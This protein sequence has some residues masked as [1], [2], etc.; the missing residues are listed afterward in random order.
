[1]CKKKIKGKLKKTGKYEKVWESMW[2]FEKV[3]EGIKKYKQ[4]LIK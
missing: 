1:M 3:R 4:A 2:K